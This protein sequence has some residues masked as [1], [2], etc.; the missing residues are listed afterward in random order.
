M[1]LVTDILQR[2]PGFTRSRAYV[3][4]LSSCCSAVATLIHKPAHVNPIAPAE[5]FKPDTP[6]T[7]DPFAVFNDFPFDKDVSAGRKDSAS[8]GSNKNSNSDNGDGDNC[9]DKNPDSDS[10]NDT[11]ARGQSWPASFPPTDPLSLT[12]SQPDSFSVPSW[13]S[14][15][16]F[17]NMASSGN[18]TNSIYR[19]NSELHPPWP[20]A[21]PVPAPP[22]QPPLPQPQPDSQ[23]GWP[24]QP[25]HLQRQLW[26]TGRQP[27]QQWPQEMDMGY[28]MPE[29][30]V[31]SW[32][33]SWLN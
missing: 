2:V 31:S 29:A 27:Q 17:A 9:S 33:E 11:L 18:L 8:N 28:L 21:S 20:P 15:F 5:S 1:V 30:G 26:Q 22:Y 32:G 10:L 19:T 7:D 16:D 23:G 24:Q 6:S 14:N 3:T 25:Q 12:S 13:T 4:Y